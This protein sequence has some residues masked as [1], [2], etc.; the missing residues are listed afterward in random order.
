MTIQ[1][2]NHSEIRRL[3]HVLWTKAVG[4]S[5]YN[6]AEWKQ[7]DHFIEQLIYEAQP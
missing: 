3:L 4:T 1:Q 6:K 2:T 5:D 7:M